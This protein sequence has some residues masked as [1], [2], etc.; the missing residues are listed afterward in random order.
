MKNQII[1]IRV[2]EEIKENLEFLSRE[3]GIPISDIVRKA[4]VRYV[5]NPI[6]KIQSTFIRKEDEKFKIIS[7]RSFVELILWFH[8]NRDDIDFYNIPSAFNYVIQNLNNAYQITPSTNDFFEDVDDLS[9]NLV[10]LIEF[11]NTEIKK[12]V[13]SDFEYDLS[14]I[15]DLNSFLNKISVNL[16]L[17]EQIFLFTSK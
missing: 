8:Y 9:E 1:T 2:S 13:L 14:N 15:Q 7:S 16:K 17:A 4:I 3:E 12:L 5:E 6:D 11:L 10:N